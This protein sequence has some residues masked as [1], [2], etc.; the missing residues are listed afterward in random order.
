V[1]GEVL[2][3]AP[4]TLYD[5]IGT[6]TDIANSANGVSGTDLHSQAL[7]SAFLQSDQT[8]ASG[9]NPQQTLSKVTYKLTDLLGMIFDGTLFAHPTNDPNNENLLE[10]LVRHEAGN[11]PLANGGTVTPDA[12]LTRFTTDLWKIAQEG[13]LTL[14]DANLAKT[15]TAFAMQ[16]YYENPNATS[17]DKELFS[18]G[19][20][21]I[22][23][24]R[25]D[26]AIRAWGGA[27]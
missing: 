8:A 11:A 13:G 2:S 14:T 12:M 10:R 18:D 20:G 26:E 9:S 19:S 27:A 17:A 5:R 1:Q 23:F 3:S 15:L 21:G 7:L 25:E 16:M 6:Q 4:V 22:R 24:N